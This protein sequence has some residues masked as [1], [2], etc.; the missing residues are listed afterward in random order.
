M[1]QGAVCDLESEAICASATRDIKA[2]PAV[3]V[4]NRKVILPEKLTETQ[5]N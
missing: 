1:P 3:L 2:V 5:N 4:Y